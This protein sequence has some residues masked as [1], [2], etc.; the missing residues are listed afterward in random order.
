MGAL[1]TIDPDRLQ[2][3]E[4]VGWEKASSM[5][6][7]QVSLPPMAVQAL[8]QGRKIEAIKLVRAATGLGLKDSK[9][10]VEAYLEKNASS[11]EK[12]EANSRRSGVGCV[13]SASVLMIV[14][15]TLGYQLW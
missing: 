4:I 10:A 7:R 6:P 14:T 12:Y 15:L 2:I 11:R 5:D 3:L 8:E 9:D 13:S 1:L